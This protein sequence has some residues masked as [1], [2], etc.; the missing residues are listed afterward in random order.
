MSVTFVL[1]RQMKECSTRQTE[2]WSPPFP[3]SDYASSL[4]GAHFL[5]QPFILS[6]LQVYQQNGKQSFLKKKITKKKNP[7]RHVI[8][9]WEKISTT[10]RP[11]LLRC[12]LPSADLFSTSG[13]TNTA[14]PRP[15][16]GCLQRFRCQ[17]RLATPTTFLSLLTFLR[18]YF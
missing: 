11:V 15:A 10:G 7:F 9:L 12:R 3:R 16:R 2:P 4:T 18:L 17:C 6:F 1:S 14:P 13:S 8:S 5:N